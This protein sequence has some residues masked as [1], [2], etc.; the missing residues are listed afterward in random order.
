MYISISTVCLIGAFVVFAVDPDG[1]IKSLLGLVAI[2]GTA[3]AF[4]TFLAGLLGLPVVVVAALAGYIGK[5]AA[6]ALMMAGLI[7]LV[8]PVVLF[9]I[10]KEFDVKEDAAP[11]RYPLN[12]IER[13]G[14][15]VPSVSA[16]TWM[17]PRAAAVAFAS[18][19]A[20]SATWAVI[21]ALVGAIVWAVLLPPRTAKNG[22]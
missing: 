17:Q 9:A 5:E 19:C 3:A 16:K 13:L 6:G 11:A 4:L 1:F 22:A 21:V 15:T 2:Y 8:A 10:V 18:M 12:K 20:L 14:L 7:A